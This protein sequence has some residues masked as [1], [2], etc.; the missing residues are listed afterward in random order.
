MVEFANVSL[1]IQEQQ[2]S[3]KLGRAFRLDWLHYWQ[4]PAQ[5]HATPR[6]SISRRYGE[7][8]FDIVSG[9]IIG[10]ARSSLRMFIGFSSIGRCQSVEDYGSNFS[11][12]PLICVLNDGVFVL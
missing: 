3:I 11:T 2:G 5:W 1:A 6:L 9:L 7:T 12:I 10:A 4:T 8:L